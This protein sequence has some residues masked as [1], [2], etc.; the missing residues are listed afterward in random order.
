MLDRILSFIA[1]KLNWSGFDYT[2]D[3]ST[4]NTDDT[5]VPVFR[6]RTIQHR[7][8]P[9]NANASASKYGSSWQSGN[10]LFFRRGNTVFVT[11]DPKF[12]AISARQ[13]IGTIPDGLRPPGTAYAWLNGTSN[14]LIFQADGQIIMNATSAATY[15]FSTC[16]AT[17]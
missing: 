4:N 14:Y 1:D 8:I 6:E 7:F 9:T 11:G 17:G 10:I 16:Y 12:A 3:I 5:W 13:R 15:W 2:W